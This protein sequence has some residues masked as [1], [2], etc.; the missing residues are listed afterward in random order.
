MIWYLKNKWEHSDVSDAVASM[1]IAN[2]V[3]RQSEQR[4]FWVVDETFYSAHS[5]YSACNL[6]SKA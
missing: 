6:F 2:I 5:R 3:Q 1:N 4:D